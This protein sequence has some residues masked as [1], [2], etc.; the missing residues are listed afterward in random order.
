V[1]WRR[2]LVAFLAGA[3]MVPA[4]APLELFALALVAPAVLVHLWLT[5]PGPRAAAWAGFLFGMGLFLAGVSWVYISLHRFGAM[6]APLAAFATFAFCVVLSCYF[7]LAGALQA[8]FRVPPAVRAALVIPALWTLAEWLRATLFT[9]F[10]WLSLGSATIDTPLA[11]FAP[12]GG[13]YA[14]SFVAASAAGLLWCV[15]LG[16]ARWGAAAAFV[17]LGAGGAGLRAIEW[18]AP[19]GAPFEASLVQGNVPQDFKFDPARYARTLET[20]AQ[21]AEGSR[22]RLIVLPETALPRMLDSVDPAYLARL[23]ALGKRNGGDLLLGAPTRVASGAYFNSV[24]SFGASPRQAYHK[25]HLVPFGEFVPPGFGWIVR[26][27]SVPMSDFA[28]GPAGQRP[29][30]VAGQLVAA[31]VC[32]EDAYGNELIR[33]LPEATLLV[34]VS[35]VAWFGDSLA[36]AQHLQIARARA[37]ETGRMHLTATNTGITAVIGRD[38]RVQAQLAPFAEGRLDA[39]VQGYAGATPYVRLGDWPVLAACA[40]LLL[41]AYA[42]RSR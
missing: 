35:N 13:A 20:H 36:P 3:A 19:V 10:P 40:L 14:S 16:Q 22:A 5:A 37:L 41:V 7:A 28:R 2:P 27:L 17:L 15:A 38:G 8:K 24:V 39:R 30:Q 12:L 23:E 1:T 42:R 34:N 29:L 26:V 11:G 6:P 25:S 9:G 32:Y 33:Q 31:N 18:T 21:L 4:F